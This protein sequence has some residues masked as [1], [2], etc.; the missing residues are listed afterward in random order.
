MLEIRGL[1]KSF[2]GVKASD[3]ITLDFADGSLTAVIGPNG[4]GKSTFFNCLAGD[5]DP[6]AGSIRF[7]DHE[8]LMKTHGFY[9]RHGGKTVIDGLINLFGIDSPG[10]TASLPLA[11][12]VAG[13]VPR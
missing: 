12:H 11:E 5:A 8:A 3:D 6:T 10:L 9:E 1:S 7:L 2:G 4:A 13:A